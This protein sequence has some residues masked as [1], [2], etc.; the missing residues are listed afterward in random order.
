[1]LEQSVYKEDLDY[2]L[3]EVKRRSF[4]PYAVARI[5]LP[6]FKLFQ[7][8]FLFLFFEQIGL[9]PALRNHYCIS[10]MLI[11]LGLDS[12][13]MVDNQRLTEGEKVKER[14]LTILMGDYFSG[15]Y[16]R[17][18][19]EFNQVALI[20]RW[21]EVVKKINETKLRLYAEKESLSP[22]ERLE[23]KQKIYRSV[24]ESVLRWFEADQAWFKILN[25]YVALQVYADEEGVSRE[26]LKREATGFKEAIGQLADPLIRR[27]L[28]LWLD[29]IGS[30]ELV[31]GS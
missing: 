21:A 7:L 17:Y 25:H 2:I 24:A 22:E 11:Q 31:I 12:H 20:C 27:E 8:H 19:A 6:R 15:H 5:R 29:K 23:L 10:Q 4:H 18:L 26:I 16:Y 1:M 28:T 3:N 13:D 9:K 14:Q 30:E